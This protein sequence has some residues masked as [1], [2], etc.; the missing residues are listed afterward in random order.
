MSSNTYLKAAYAVKLEHDIARKI[1]ENH[2]NDNCMAF[3][4]NPKELDA[5]DADIDEI[6]NSMLSEETNHKSHSKQEHEIYNT[7]L[8]NHNDN[9]YV[10]VGIYFDEDPEIDHYFG[11]V[12]AD[13]GY[14]DKIKGFE[15]GIPQEALDRY[16]QFV[17]PILKL[18]GVDSTPE[19]VV[20]QQTH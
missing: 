13:T 14:G 5:D 16:E 4:I 18:Y 2:Y 1:Y 3:Y 6:L 10:E 19:L 8:L 20:V 12:L 9:P 15:K 17:V 7:E 11:I